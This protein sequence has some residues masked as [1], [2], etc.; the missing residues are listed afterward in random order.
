MTT[1][2]Q[3][4]RGTCTPWLTVLGKCGQ[5]SHVHQPAETYFRKHVWVNGWL[6]IDPWCLQNIVSQFQSSTFGQN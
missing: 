1:P 6:K 4:R 5:Q 2:M 3:C